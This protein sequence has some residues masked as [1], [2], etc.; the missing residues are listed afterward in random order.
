MIEDR[1]DRGHG[2][3]A[4]VFDR[5]HR[6]SNVVERSAG[7]D[8]HRRR[9]RAPV[10]RRRRRRGRGG[11]SR[12]CS[13]APAEPASSQARSMASGAGQ[14]AGQRRVEVDHLVREPAEEAHREDAHPTGEH[15][16]VGLE[17]GDDVGEAGVVVRPVLAGCGP[18]WT[19][20][21]RRPRR[22]AAARTRPAGSRR[23]RR[24]RPSMRPSAHA[25]RI[26]CRFDPLPETSTT[27]GSPDLVTGRRRPW[28]EPSDAVRRES[29]VN[30]KSVQ[31]DDTVPRRA[32]R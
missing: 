2:A 9:W 19:A 6:R 1:A 18:M 11:P 4:V 20:G 26:A 5:V 27:S 15:D 10:R 3:R 14:L 7:V 25:S 23:R 21:T 13:V 8:R 17:P 28:I 30:E 29:S 32:R 31:T 22:P 12:R 24:P 16:P